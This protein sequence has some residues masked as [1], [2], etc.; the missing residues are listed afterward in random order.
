MPAI[1][2]VQIKIKVDQDVVCC[3][4]L[5]MSKKQQI[6]DVDAKEIP[7]SGRVLIVNVSLQVSSPIS[8]HC[9]MK[10]A[11]QFFQIKLDNG[12]VLMKIIQ[13]QDANSNARPAIDSVLVEVQL[14][15]VAVKLRNQKS[16]K[17]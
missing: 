13:T 12:V 17:N 14:A 10:S 11:R 2:S 4:L 6:E 8:P 1:G 5:D 9:T 16:F 15:V 3:V 7:V